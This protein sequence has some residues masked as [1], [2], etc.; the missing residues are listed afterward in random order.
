M[1]NINSKYL[2]LG[3]WLTVAVLALFLALPWPRANGLTGPQQLSPSASPGNSIGQTSLI[4]G[5]SELSPDQ[6]MLRLFARAAPSATA[7]VK[8]VTTSPKP[9]QAEFGPDPGLRL[10]G[11]M[12]VDQTRKWLLKDISNGLSFAI[13]PGEA[14]GGWTCLGADGGYLILERGGIRYRVATN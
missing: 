4:Y 6:L 9:T 1:R 13:S 10:I 3:L 8:P 7:I 5:Q 11:S 12:V 14:Y 2:I